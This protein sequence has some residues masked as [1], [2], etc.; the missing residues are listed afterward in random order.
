MSAEFNKTHIA[1]RPSFSN[2]L[3]FVRIQ[4]LVPQASLPVCSKLFVTVAFRFLRHLVE[5]ELDSRPASFSLLDP[6]NAETGASKSSNMHYNGDIFVILHT[7]FGFMFIY[8]R[9]K[10][11]VA[12]T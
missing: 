10:C 1:K 12:G 3:F 8:S 11:A 9:C 4:F 5:L 6:E 2:P 7:T